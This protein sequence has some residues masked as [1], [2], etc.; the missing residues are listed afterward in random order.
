MIRR[1]GNT[2]PLLIL[3]FAMCVLK[4]YGDNN[5]VQGFDPHHL[6]I[7]VEG[8]SVAKVDSLFKIKYIAKYDL[9]R[10]KDVEFILD[11]D[12]S[13][14]T[15]RYL[16][17]L[18]TLTATS[19]QTINHK[20]I[21]RK[22]DTWT[23]TWRAVNQGVFISPSYRVVVTTNTGSDT[24]N[25][26]PSTKLVKIIKPDIDLVKKKEKELRDLVRRCKDNVLAEA[27]LQN[28]EYTV[29]DTI[30]CKLVLLRRK[31]IP[32][33]HIDN[34]SISKSISIK[35][36][37]HKIILID[38]PIFDEYN[39]YERMEIAEIVITPHKKGVIKIPQIVLSGD[40]LI[41]PN[42]VFRG[43]T[44]PFMYKA[45]TNPIQVRVN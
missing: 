38:E 36:C 19:I 11:N 26:Q 28:L 24:I 16:F 34:V 42:D 15:A 3:G 7:K 31:G 13:N 33:I 41:C 40:A 43:K 27:Q 32:N 35:D 37:T 9:G 18:P 8:D 2:I 22:E 4:V 6:S 39:G 21:Q 23:A 17:C 14:L 44:I 45:T 25:M 5:S 20:T 10:I 29:G 12:S 30:H 1:S